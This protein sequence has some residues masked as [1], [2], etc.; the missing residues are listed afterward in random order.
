MATKETDTKYSRRVHKGRHEV[1]VL[2]HCSG[3]SGAQ[4]TALREALGDRCQVLTPDLYG[5]GEADAWPGQRAFALTEEATAIESLFPAD[6][7]GVH[8]IGHSYG[9]AVA[10]RLASEHPQRIRSLTLIEPVAFHLLRAPPGKEPDPLLE[11]IQTVSAAVLQAMRR[12]DYCAGM[13]HFVDYWSGA[14][15]WLRT[16]EQSRT[17]LCRCIGKVVLDFHAAMNE[18][19]SGEAY[20]RFAFPILLICGERSPVPTRRIVELLHAVMT[21]ARL[22]AIP[23][24]GHMAPITHRDI[25]NAAIIDHLMRSGA[26]TSISAAAA[27]CSRADG[28]PRRGPSLSGELDGQALLSAQQPA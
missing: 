10:L 9:G 28:R 26:W 7:R 21:K 12:G 11:E 14:G 27:P 18:P 24:A 2:L 20:G 4:W 13:A 16:S 6:G 5:Y 15:S 19:T 25:V 17:T 23:G 22:K 3:S 8:L 1:V